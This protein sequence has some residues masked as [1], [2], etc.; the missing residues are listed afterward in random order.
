[1]SVEKAKEFLVE[2]TNSRESA[3]KAGEAYLEALMKVAGELGYQV[4]E[5]D[6]RS[7]MDEMSDLSELSEQSL[8]AV[9]AGGRTGYND[10]LGVWIVGSLPNDSVFR[11]SYLSKKE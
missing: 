6:L 1:M 5:Q 7:A 3:G 9:A 2:L 8:E 10:S 4:E 11:L